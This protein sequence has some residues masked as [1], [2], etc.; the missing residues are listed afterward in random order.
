MEYIFLNNNN[1][2]TAGYSYGIKPQFVTPLTST[3]NV[4]NEDDHNINT[5][6]PDKSSTIENNENNATR[7]TE[8]VSPQSVDM[9]IFNDGDSYIPDFFLSNIS[10]TIFLIFIS[11]A[12]II[13]ASKIDNINVSYLIIAAISLLI[14]TEYGISI[15]I[16]LFA[17]IMA[18]NANAFILV[19]VVIS[20]VHIFVPI[21]WLITD[22]FNYNYLLQGI[23]GLL[24]LLAI[25][26]KKLVI[27]YAIPKE[28]T[29]VFKNATAAMSNESTIISY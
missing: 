15:S 10:D 11:T 7:T 6:K 8:N 3:T 29:T 16:V 13:A 25:N 28:T 12:A 4:Q 9:S 22:S 5:I 26:Y 19:L 17:I 21:P 27:Y 18:N 1:T 14:S 20:L 2:Y 24:T 23:L